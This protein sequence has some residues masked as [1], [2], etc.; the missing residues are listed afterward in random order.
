[1]QLSSNV[2]A[3]CPESEYSGGGVETAERTQLKI[4]QATQLSLLCLQSVPIKYRCS[5]EQE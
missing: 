5:D 3:F 1:M 4:W 2:S